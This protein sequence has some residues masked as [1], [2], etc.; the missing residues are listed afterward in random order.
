MTYQSIRLYHYGYWKGFLDIFGY[1]QGFEL[2]RYING[3]CFV[4]FDKNE[5]LGLAKHLSDK[6]TDKNF[7]VKTVRKLPEKINKDFDAYLSFVEKMPQNLTN[8]S[9]D[10]LVNTLETFFN[11]QKTLSINFWILFT[12]VEV[13]LNLAVRELMESKKIASSRID[14]LVSKLSEP[15]K[16]IPIDMEKLSL[17]RIALLNKGKQASALKRH[18]KNYAYMPVYDIDYNPYNLDYFREKL[19]DINKKLS[20]DEIKKENNT[21]KNK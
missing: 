13:A 3:D 16:I 18:W 7:I 11:K 19:E 1:K 6:F 4:Y 8:F 9:N 20:K 17:L 10:K 12:N 14:E 2:Y 21:I 5:A 15:I